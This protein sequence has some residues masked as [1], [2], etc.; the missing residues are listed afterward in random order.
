MKLTDRT[1]SLRKLHIAIGVVVVL[2]LQTGLPHA[3]SKIDT[4]A[5]MLETMKVSQGPAGL[6]VIRWF[7]EPF[8]AASINQSATMTQ[9]QTEDFLKVLRPYTM[10]MVVSGTIGPFGGM[11]YKSASEIRSSIKLRDG[12]GNTYS[13]LGNDALD[14][15]TRNFLEIAKPMLKG[16]LGPLGEN[17]HVVLF[18]SKSADGLSIAD[19]NKKGSF[20]VLLANEEFRWR[21]PLDSVLPP[22]QCPTC[23]EECRGSW[24][25]CP[26][27]GTKLSSPPIEGLAFQAQNAAARTSTVESPASTRASPPTQDSDCSLDLIR[28][29][30]PDYPKKAKGANVTGEVVLKAVIGKDGKPKNVVYLSGHP[31]LAKAAVGAV[32]KWRYE[33]CRLKEGPVEVATRIR[34]T[35]RLDA[36]GTPSFSSNR[37][38]E[39]ERVYFVNDSGIRRP[40]LTYGPD[41]AYT[42]A[43]RKAGIQGTVVLSCTVTSTGTV[44]NVTVSKSLDPQLDQQAI[45]A[46]RGWRFDPAIKDGRPVSVW[47]LVEVKFVLN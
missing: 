19:P 27:C 29:T 6:T 18:Q 39:V 2:L 28:Q 21:L 35:F 47:V 26:W 20:S 36:N 33:P 9:S 10:V 23:K 4:Q 13:P 14:Q 32:S 5:M 30:W 25:Y 43:A 46:V 37:S 3:Q 11:T 8:W 17:M 44:R 41:P 22:K 24:S 15:D 45:E 31:L 16:M 38:D 1:I 34:I 42:E 40:S 7:P 12:D